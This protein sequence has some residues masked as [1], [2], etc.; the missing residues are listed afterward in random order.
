MLYADDTLV[1]GEEVEDHILIF[2]VIFIVFE[3]V[4]GLHINWGKIFIYPIN[5]V[6]DMEG[7]AEKLEL[8]TTYLGMP[9]GAK[10]KSKV[11]WNGVVKECEKRLNN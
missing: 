4:S 5:A 9:L 6:I 11:I 3:A 8:P 1:F 7:M 10:R 2:R